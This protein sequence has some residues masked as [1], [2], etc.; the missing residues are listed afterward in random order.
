MCWERMIIMLKSEECFS[1]K[2]AGLYNRMLHAKNFLRT[3]F[4]EVFHSFV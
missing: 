2:S 1:V 4:L 3:N